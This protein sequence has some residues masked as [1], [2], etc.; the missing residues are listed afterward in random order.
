MK[1]ASTVI[2]DTVREYFNTVLSAHF[3]LLKA[4]SQYQNVR[5]FTKSNLCPILRSEQ[6]HSGSKKWNRGTEREKGQES[7]VTGT[8][9]APLKRCSF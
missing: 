5:S 7:F 2:A 1:F 4:L 3:K 9:Y 8:K 6:N